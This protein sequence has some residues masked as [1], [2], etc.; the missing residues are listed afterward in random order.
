MLPPCANL[1]HKI[2]DRTDK[3][4]GVLLDHQARP[5]RMASARGVQIPSLSAQC[6]ADAVVAVLKAASQHVLMPLTGRVST[7]VAIRPWAYALRP[8]AFSGDGLVCW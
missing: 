3:A 7:A 1:P 5:G 6:S 8:S 4:Q 2:D